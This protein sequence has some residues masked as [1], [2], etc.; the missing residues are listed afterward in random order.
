MSR[1]CNNSNS[2]SNSN[3]SSN[4]NSRHRHNS[5]RHSSCWLRRGLTSTRGIEDHLLKTIGKAGFK[6]F[7]P[8]TSTTTA[9]P[10]VQ[11]QHHYYYPSEENQHSHS[12]PRQYVPPPPPPSRY[13]LAQLSATA[14]TT[15]TARPWVPPY[16]PWPYGWG[17]GYPGYTRYPGYPTY[18]GYP[19]YPG[20]PVYPGY[21]GYPGY[22]YYPYYRSSATEE[23]DESA[24]ASAAAVMQSE[25]NQRSIPGSYQARVLAS[26]SNLVAGKSNGDVLPLYQLL[27]V[28]RV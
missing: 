6:Y 24:A 15:A 12:H 19:T 27:N 9:K 5:S 18:T 3:N 14:S 20:Y 13:P 25:L 1:P 4:N 8:T 23:T 28:A 11:H 2:N 7:A 21:T 10:V 22:P 16:N 26:T 17:N